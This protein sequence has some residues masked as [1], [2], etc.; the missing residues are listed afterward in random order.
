[1]EYR[2]LGRTGVEVSPCAWAPMMLGDWGKNNDDDS[3]RIIYH[4]L[5]SGIDFV[6]TADWLTARTTTV[7]IRVQFAFTHWYLPEEHTI[8]HVVEPVCSGFP[9]VVVIVALRSWAW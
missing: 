2:L 6:D 7:S 3:T 5:D 4:A 9:Q 1:M 8:I